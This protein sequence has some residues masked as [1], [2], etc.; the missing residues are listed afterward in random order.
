MRRGNLKRE[1]YYLFFSPWFCSFCQCLIYILYLHGSKLRIQYNANSL[2]WRNITIDS[3]TISPLPCLRT[4]L[5]SSRRLLMLYRTIKACAIRDYNHHQ[6]T[7]MQSIPRGRCKQQ[8]L[9]VSWSHSCSG[10]LAGRQQGLSASYHHLRVRPTHLHTQSYTY[11][12]RYVLSV[13]M[14]RDHLSGKTHT[15]EYSTCCSRFT[16]ADTELIN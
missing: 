8:E 1:I 12:I 7:I 4:F 15:E 13:S 2:K 9:C 3:V 14:R 10:I 5:D 16:E 11:R 6:I